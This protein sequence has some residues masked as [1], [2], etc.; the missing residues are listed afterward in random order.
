M[1]ANIASAL[2]AY[3]KTARPDAGGGMTPRPAAD[4]GSDFGTLLKDAVN[5]LS[6][7]GR[8][9]EAKT[10]EAVAGKADLTDV[11]TAVTNAEITL[12]TAVAIRDRV[13][14]AYQDILRMPL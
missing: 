4:P 14:S 9:A 11:V 12:Q 7:T 10:M 5:T 2:S 1:P 8:E 13:I 6:E 3:A